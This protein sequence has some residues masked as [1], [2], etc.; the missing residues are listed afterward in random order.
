MGIPRGLNYDTIAFVILENLHGICPLFV[1]LV[2][3]YQITGGQ[4][5]QA[6]LSNYQFLA[7]FIWNFRNDVIFNNENIVV[8][9][10]VSIYSRFESG[11]GYVVKGHL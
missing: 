8:E 1:D 5:Y 3:F 11:I 7:F 4:F 6:Y 2:V 10:V 9:R